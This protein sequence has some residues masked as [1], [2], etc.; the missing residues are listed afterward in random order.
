MSEGL[1]TSGVD[2]EKDYITRAGRVYSAILNFS[3]VTRYFLY[4]LPF[5]LLIAIPII[6]GATAATDAKIGGVRLVW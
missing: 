4:V 2:D 1:Q 6:V 5:A 3:I